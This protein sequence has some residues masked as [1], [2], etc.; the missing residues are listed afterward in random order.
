MAPDLDDRAARLHRELRRLPWPRAPHT[1]VPRVLAALARPWYTREWLAWPF[2]WQAASLAA[3][4]GITA[5]VWMVASSPQVVELASF[6]ES[7]AAA[8]RVLWRLVLQP[9]VAYVLVLS[10]VACVTC[11]AG[12]AALSRLAFSGVSR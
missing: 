10:I 12:W 5:G 1:L 4:L 11:A 2:Q 9:V 8:A 3:A 6:G 7:L